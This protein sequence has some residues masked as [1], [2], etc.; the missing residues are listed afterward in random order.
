MKI[1]GISC[2]YHD[3]SASII[4]NNKIEACAQEERFTRIKHTP[5]FPINAIKYCLEVTGLTINEIDAIVFYDKPVVKFE[6]LISTFYAV[7]PRGLI[8]FLKAIPIWL[9]EKLFLKKTIID[10]LK[11]IDSNLDKKNLKLLFTEHH[12][13]H[14]ASTFYPSNFSESAILTID[15][16]GE[17]CTASICYGEN[18]N[19]KIIKELH[20]PHSVGLLYSAFTYYLGFR[21]NSGE[22]KLMGL[23]PYGIEK[24]LETELFIKKIKTHIVDIKDDG[25]IFLNQKYFKYTYGLK[26]TKDSEFERLL[27]LSVRLEE[28]QIT[29]THCNLAL[30]IQKVTEEIVIKMVKETKRLTNS[31]NLCLSGGVALNCVANGKIED[32]QIFENIYI[33]PASGDA[34]GSLGS[35]LAINHMYFNMSR[36]Y[37]DDYDLMQGAYLGPYYSF[38]E[39]V[40]TNKRNKAVC[41]EFESFNDLSEYVAKLISQGKIIGWFQGRSEFGPRALGN[42]SILADPRN[43]EMQRKLNLN[44]KYREGFRPFAPSVLEEDYHEF[45]EGQIISPYMLMVKKIKREIK[46]TLPQEYH[47]LNYMEKLYTDRS[48]LQSITHVDFSARIQTVNRKTNKKYWTLIND[49]KKISG[50]GVLV[51]TS[52]NVRGEPIVNTPDN[53]Y[54]CFM[55]TEMDYLVI[56]NFLYSKRDNKGNYEK[57]KFKKD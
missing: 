36:I 56:E 46:K 16:V 26:M 4:V 41:K 49:F 43:P 32:L 30:A 34:G 21:V 52:F 54:K 22:Y 13:S 44:I 5:D 31:K 9:K 42:R 24:S 10:N 47:S 37:T 12:I 14:A 27:G 19:I 51:N 17:W 28:D 23:A 20:F 3:A 11:L 6:R 7:A 29:Q 8:P 39:I 15:G 25:S 48:S 40:Q 50:I 55:N 2:F 18:K 45:F 38:K 57:I 35:A 33:Q 1:I 53:A